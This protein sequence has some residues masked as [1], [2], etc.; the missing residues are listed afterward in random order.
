[1]VP[2]ALPCVYIAM[3]RLD[4]GLSVLIGRTCGM[5]Q[6]KLH[7]VA[8]ACNQNIPGGLGGLM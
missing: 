7:E 3:E 4:N 2:L 8:K 6:L 1:M 5:E